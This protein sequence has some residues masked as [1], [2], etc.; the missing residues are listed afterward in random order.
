M[1]SLLQNTIFGNNKYRANTFIGGV[2]SIINTPALVASKLGVPASRIKGFKIIE[3]NIEFAVTGGRYSIAVGAFMSVTA[4][5]YYY[6]T[7]YLI[8]GLGTYAFFNAVN[9]EFISELRNCV[10]M[11]TGVF[12]NNQKLAAVIAPKLQIAGEACFKG[13]NKVKEFSFPE[14][15]TLNSASVGG[16]T[17]IFEDCV[18][19]EKVY[20]PKCTT[21]TG[22][23]LL[24]NCNSLQSFYAPLLN[25]LG[26][27]LGNDSSF[28]GIKTGAK[29][30]VS[31]YLKTVNAGAPDGDLAI[32]ET[33]TG[34]TII[35][36]GV[37]MVGAYGN[38]YQKSFDDGVSFISG[39]YISSTRGI[40]VSETTK[41]V[42]LAY[43]SG[44][45]LS[46]DFGKNFANTTLA[47]TTY[48]CVSMSDNGQYMLASA[49]SGST[50]LS[51]DYGVTWNLA[52][53]GGRRDCFV[54]GT[55]QYML[56]TNI[57]GAQINRS[58]DYGVTW[59][60]ITGQGIIS[61]VC[62]SDDGQFIIAISNGGTIRVSNDG[63][64]TWTNKTAYGNFTFPKVAMSVDGKYQTIA[65]QNKYIY[66]SSD[67]GVTW[68]ANTSTFNNLYYTCMDMSKD[69]KIQA[70]AVSGGYIYV[71]NDFGV[72]W[73]QKSNARDYQA[74][75]ISN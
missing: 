48:Y 21:V 60:P 34:A 64:T 2:A 12:F 75:A 16:N 51:T 43:N 40:A 55:G 19:L 6:D 17:G 8:E 44:V 18:L 72:T 47:A 26:Q 58:T 36:Q 62:C 13:M 23:R 50:H 65:S 53:T 70:T 73:I 71:S 68:T 14:L 1:G 67:Y 7:D 69:G 27:T 33:A 32:A 20:V 4:L 35:Y 39:G 45:V 11:G 37:I 29:L 63:G 24:R 66:T 31:A 22:Y 3:D 59:T 15:T 38:N 28:S 25:Q 54:S 10:T 41:Y 42:L 74:I 56:A 30:T 5:T 46:S 57:D 9:L 61:S 49:S 52:V